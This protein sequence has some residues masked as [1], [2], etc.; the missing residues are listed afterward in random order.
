M[1]G[2]LGN[3]VLADLSAFGHYSQAVYS[4][5]VLQ[6]CFQNSALLNAAITIVAQ[7]GPQG[8][9]PG[10]TSRESRMANK[11]NLMAAADVLARE[12][13]RLISLKKLDKA[14]EMGR[15]IRKLGFL[16]KE[17]PEEPG[18]KLETEKP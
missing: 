5:E 9:L 6:N 10:S 18:Y 4:A 2:G 15:A 1:T 12:R 11:Q 17:T 7:V 3:S 14:A 16:L 13:K 8:M